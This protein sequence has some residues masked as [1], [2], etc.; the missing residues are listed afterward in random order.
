MQAPHGGVQ[1]YL[2]QVQEEVLGGA[3]DRRLAAHF[4]LGILDKTTGQNNVWCS[5]K[6]I[7]IIL[8][9]ITYTLFLITCIL[10]LI[11]NGDVHK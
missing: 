6:K 8:Y 1:R 3:D 10:I 2:G 7:K 9:H 5:G 11:E 4:A